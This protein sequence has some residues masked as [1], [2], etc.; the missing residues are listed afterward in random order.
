VTAVRQKLDMI[1]ENKVLEKL[2]LSKNNSY[3]KYSSKLLF[4]IKKNDKGF[5]YIILM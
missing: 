2:K 1:L 5:D 3:K 4:P